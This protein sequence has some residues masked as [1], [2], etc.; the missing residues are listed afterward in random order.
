MLRETAALFFSNHGSSLTVSAGFC[1]HVSAC[2]SIW[3]CR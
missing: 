1:I 2:Q 3:L